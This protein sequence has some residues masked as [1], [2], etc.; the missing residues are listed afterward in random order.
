[1]VVQHNLQAMNANRMLG[2]TTKVVSGSTEKLSSG[3]RINRAA[4]DAAGLAISEKMRKQ[5]RGLT[6]AASNAEDGISCVQT[7]EGA[8]AE[9]Q[10]MLQRMNE[11]CV[12]AANGTNSSTDRLY[13]QDELDQL[14]SEIDRIAETTKFN[15]T[16]LLKGDQTGATTSVYITNYSTTFTKNTVPNSYNGTPTT[17]CMNYI[18][19]NNLYLVSSKI[20]DSSPSISLG[21]DVIGTGEDITKYMEKDNTTPSNNE[22][23]AKLNTTSYTAFINVELNSNTQD[24]NGDL[25]IDNITEIVRARQELFIYN[26]ENDTVTRIT[27]GTAMTQYL[28][29]NNAMKDQYRLVDYVD[30]SR[31]GTD[32]PTGSKVKSQVTNNN[33]YQWDNDKLVIDESMQALYNAD[34]QQVSGIAL[35]QY[36]DEQGNYRGGLFKTS[37]A[38][39]KDEIVGTTINQYITQSS[40]QIAEGLTFQLHVG[41]QSERKN[42]ISATI[43]TLT[44]AG[45]GI[46]MLASYN[47]GIV[48]ETGENATDA[49]D[50]IDD[51]LQQLSRQRSALGAVQNRLDHTIKNLDNIVENTTAAESAIRDTDMAEEMVKYANANILQQA[52]QS[53]LAQANQSNEG[54]LS[55]LQ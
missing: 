39:A 31:T 40:K 8:L 43:D 42:K 26:T 27:A 44:A 34:G 51:A 47:I 5:V 22:G 3:Y 18:G 32:G 19:T 25:Y 9:V 54:V 29:D 13:I 11:L 6:Q 38:T 2:L 20:L 53:M 10:D 23:K 14:I 12:Q 28:D 49:I 41:A 16:F 4:D 45:L 7:A 55:L 48:D 15:E 17:Y 46:E 24:Q 50:V 1:M 33:E 37:Q 35:H 36:F 52:G 30:S 21:A